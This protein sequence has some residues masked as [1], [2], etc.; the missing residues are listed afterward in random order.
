MMEYN[1]TYIEYC[2][3]ALAHHRGIFELLG[4]K[5]EYHGNVSPTHSL[6][7]YQFVRFLDYYVINF[8][9]TYVHSCLLQ[10][11]LTFLMALSS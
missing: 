6:T 5:S 10:F 9:E 11:Q 2:K 1:S 3:I 4:D 7:H 8:R